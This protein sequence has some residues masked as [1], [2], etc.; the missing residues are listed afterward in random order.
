[1]IPE[2]VKPPLRKMRLDWLRMSSEWVGNRSGQPASHACNSFV[3][4]VGCGRS[5][6]TLI[7]ECLRR[8]QGVEYLFEP[9]H[10][11]GVVDRRTD[12]TN[13]HYDVFPR[14]FMDGDAATSDAR[15]KLWRLVNWK[16]SKSADTR[17]VVEKTPHNVA[18]IGFLEEMIPG[19]RYIHIVRNGMDVAL[20]ISRI[21]TQSKVRITGKP[22]YNQWWGTDNIRWRT[23]KAES[24]SRGLIGDE[25]FQLETELQRA[26][27]EWVISVEEA[28]RWQ[29][30]LG[31]RFLEV[32]YSDLTSDAAGQLRGL[33]TFL[34]LPVQNEWL[35]Q[36]SALIRPE[37]HS[38]VALRL[39]ASLCSRFNHWQSVFG[40]PGRATP[41]E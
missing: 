28:K 6:T 16:T 3:F 9:Y 21:A 38:D 18:R 15:E 5:G 14:Y 33:A 4:I 37:R 13:L 17:I 7:G 23:L 11:W 22:T 27:F 25:I 12:V 24:Q 10:L 36:T 32:S 34:G 20:S 29:A 35:E 1:M 31:N 19:S 8:H 41:A 30:Q 2:T 40:F 39:P 26:A